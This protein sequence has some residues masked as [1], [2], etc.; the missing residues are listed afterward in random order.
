MIEESVWNTDGM[1]LRRE[2]RRTE[3]NTGMFCGAID[4]PGPKDDYT[5]HLVQ[6]LE[7]M[8]VYLHYPI[9]VQGFMFSYN[10]LCK[11]SREC[12]NM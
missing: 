7:W 2:S 4:L 6:M 8:E 5:V 12:R 9:S 10:V 11:D 3:I 1:I